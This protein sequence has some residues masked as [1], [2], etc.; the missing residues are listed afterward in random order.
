MTP[1]PASVPPEF[2]VTALDPASEPFT[3]SVPALTVV[4]PV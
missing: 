3:P 2:T 4:G 1:L